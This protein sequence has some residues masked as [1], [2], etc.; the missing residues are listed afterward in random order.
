MPLSRSNALLAALLASVI[1]VS[2]T[3]TAPAGPSSTANT[4]PSCRA[5]A[6][7]YRTVTTFTNSGIVATS[8]ASCSF[9]LTTNQM[10]CSV[11]SADTAG[12]SNTSS[13]VTTYRS[14]A[15]FVTE[16]STNPPLKRSLNTTTSLGGPI[17]PVVT[18]T[19]NTYDTQG[20]LTG[21]SGTSSTVWTAWDSQGRPVTGIAVSPAGFRTAV[22]VSYNDT[23]RAFMR[24]EG[25]ST[26][27]QTFD[28]NGNVTSLTCGPSSTVTI[29]TATSTVCR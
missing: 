28:A 27:T 13:S 25:L 5:Y 26:C 8:L 12:A 14:A 24:T 21:E 7:R 22:S 19:D 9:D 29:T 1:G 11:L 10:S 4:S 6:S 17:D 16:V 20:R 18:R 15:D 3:E 2:C 23:S